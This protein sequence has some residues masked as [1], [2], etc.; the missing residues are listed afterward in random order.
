MNFTTKVKGGGALAGAMVFLLSLLAVFVSPVL[1]RFVLPASLTLVIPFGQA[2]LFIM[3]Y[4]VLP[5]VLG[6]LALRMAP[7]AAPKLSRL[8]GL[9]AGIVFLWF[10]V[11]SGGVRKLAVGEI[12]TMAVGAMVLFIAASMAIGW[13][14]GGAS[15]DSR[16]ILATAT[17]MRNAA[18]C[19]EIVEASSPGHPVIVPL[20]AFSLLMVMANTVFAT[21]HGIQARLAARI[22][23]HG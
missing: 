1:L 10:S 11:I 5:L 4:L 13:L 23:G 8:L 19:L 3:V 12:G 21:Y 7:G 16:R 6:M 22:V 2:L 20:I 14:L 9:A 18:L 17:S 15:R